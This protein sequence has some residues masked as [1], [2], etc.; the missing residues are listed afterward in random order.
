MLVGWGRATSLCVIQS[1][2]AVSSLASFLRT[3]QLFIM[4]NIGM[5]SAIALPSGLRP[6]LRRGVGKYEFPKAYK[7]A[8]FLRVCYLAKAT[9][10]LSLL[11]G[12]RSPISLRLQ[13]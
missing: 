5:T 2:S 12:S 11:F 6:K 8:Y 13:Q 7:K 3:F 4:K 9:L 10:A 1:G